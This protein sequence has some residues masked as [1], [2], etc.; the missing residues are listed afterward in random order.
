MSPTTRAQKF[1]LVTKVLLILALVVLLV[2]GTAT[3]VDQLE[4]DGTFAPLTTSG[5]FLLINGNGGPPPVIPAGTGLMFDTGTWC[6]SA[7]GDLKTTVNIAVKSDDIPAKRTVPVIVGLSLTVPPG[8]NEHRPINLALPTPLV[9][10]TWALLVT[11]TVIEGTGR[12]QVH[13]LTSEPFVI[14]GVA[15]SPTPAALA[16]H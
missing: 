10:G 13:T 3:V 4:P 14:N 12:A 16:P 2:V 1:S 9:Q 5:E 8:C 11:V 15:A 6:S 7:K